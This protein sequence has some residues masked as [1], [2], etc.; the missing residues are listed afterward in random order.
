MCGV[1]KNLVEGIRPNQVVEKATSRIGKDGKQYPAS[2]PRPAEDEPKITF[3]ALAGLALAAQAPTPIPLPIPVS[4][5][6]TKSPFFH[7]PMPSMR[8]IGSI[9]HRPDGA[10]TLRNSCRSATSWNLRKYTGRRRRNGNPK[11]ERNTGGGKIAPVHRGQKL[12][13][14]GI[15][16]PSWPAMLLRPSIPFR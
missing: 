6:V 5:S 2:R 10:A 14:Q 7:F 12:S 3:V 15:P 4:E 1:G 11:P 16:A 8:S 9:R 13:E